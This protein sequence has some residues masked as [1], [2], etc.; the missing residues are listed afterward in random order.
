MTTTGPDRTGGGDRPVSGPDFYAHVAT[1]AEV[2]GVGI[3]SAPGDWE[4]VLGAD[5]VDDPGKGLLRRDHGLVEISFSADGGP[6]S[7]FGI[8]VQAHRLIHGQGVPPALARAYGEFA[9]RVRFEEVRAGIL[10]L[11]CTVEPDD[12]SGDVHRYRVPESGVRVF[13]VDDPDPYG[14]GDHDV[15]DPELHQAGD[16]WS[17]SVSPAW[18]ERSR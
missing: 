10:A 16:I 14:D 11:G 5:C 6:L 7:C 2:L 13:V 18:W 3:G 12:L 4:A 8:S 15:H 1:R 9:P 17:L